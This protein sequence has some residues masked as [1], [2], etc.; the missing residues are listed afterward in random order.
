MYYICT[1]E[2]T[3]L[4]QSVNVVNT[5]DERTVG[6]LF[7]RLLPFYVRRSP[8]SSLRH[9]PLQTGA[10]P[11]ELDAG[12]LYTLFLKMKLSLIVI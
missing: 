12:G 6:T 8:G 3:F 4:Y 1:I 5:K 9:P 11:T 2:N 10:I 7:L